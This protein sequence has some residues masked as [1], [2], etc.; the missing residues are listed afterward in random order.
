MKKYKTLIIIMVLIA[1]GTIY[2]YY[3]SENS[4]TKSNHKETTVS[5][6][7]KLINKDLD[8][9]Y[10]STPR[11]VVDVFSKIL[12][13][14]YGGKCSDD[15]LMSL[16]LQSRKLFDEELLDRNPLDEYM[17]NLK[18]EIA[19][20]REEKKKISTYIIEKTGEIQYKTFQS[21]YYAMVDGVY[22]IKGEG[23]TSRTM[24]TY[25]LRKDSNGKWK[26]LYWSLMDT[27]EE[28]E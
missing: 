19:Q 23:G 28:D 3:L 4:K 22:Y 18:D 14:Y 16:V 25:T 10:P 7:D 8:S 5:E 15:E 1:M 12:T 24:E 21:H 27:D 6:V 2:Y 9:N 20:Y 13:C 11:E 17:D 26:I